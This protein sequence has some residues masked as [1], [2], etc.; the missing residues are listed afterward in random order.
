MVRDMPKRLENSTDEKDSHDV[1]RWRR[2]E[3]MREK[4]ELHEALD[5]IGANT[6][7]C[8]EEVFGSDEE[9]LAFHEH[10]DE[11]EDELTDID[12][13]E[14]ALDDDFEDFEDD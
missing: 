12:D 14:E 7:E 9:Y 3:I 4:A 2:I 11:P 5:D 10:S 1:P 13:E 6:D 8:D